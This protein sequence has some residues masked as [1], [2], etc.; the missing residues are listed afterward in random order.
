MCA[1]VCVLEKLRG[2]L[3]Q[4]AETCRSKPGFAQ[5]PGYP[6]KLSSTSAP[7]NPDY[8]LFLCSLKESEPEQE[9][10]FQDARGRLSARF[11]APSHL[12]QPAVIHSSSPHIPT[13]AVRST[14]ESHGV[15][16]AMTLIADCLQSG[17]NSTASRHTT[18]DQT[19]VIHQWPLYSDLC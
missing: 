19:G 2:G 10:R 13:S 1:C 4:I 9:M 8:L 12:H 5:S 18:T 7:Q 17:S 16:A 11:K 3:G 15:A 6:F 14:L